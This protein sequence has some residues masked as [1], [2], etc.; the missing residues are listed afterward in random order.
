M[1]KDDIIVAVTAASIIV[2]TALAANL[3]VGAAIMLI[4]LVCIN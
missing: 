1:K 3:I 2:G 4:K